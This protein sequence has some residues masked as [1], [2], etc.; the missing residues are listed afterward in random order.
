MHCRVSLI[1]F[2]HRDY[3]PHAAGATSRDLTL[4]PSFSL[5]L[6]LS[7]ICVAGRQAVEEKPD[8]LRWT[9]MGSRRGCPPLPC[10]CKW[11]GSF[12]SAHSLAQV[13]RAIDGGH[14]WLW[15]LIG[16]CLR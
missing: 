12:A 2:A 14:S 7:W 4:N 8:R 11:C 5:P 3:R 15:T 6:S 1:C 10:K 13:P 9:R 16:R